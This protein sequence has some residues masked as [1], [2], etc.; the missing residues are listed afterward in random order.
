M[1]RHIARRVFLPRVG[2]RRTSQWVAHGHDIQGSDL[3]LHLQYLSH[4]F[5]IEGANLHRSQA[6]G[7]SLK[8]NV[9]SDVPRFNANVS[10]T[11]P[12]IPVGGSAVESADN[13]V[14]RGVG[15]ES[16]IE[17]RRGELSP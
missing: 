7:R 11:T 4:L 9:L 12:A 17:S 14:H 5:V 1:P 15:N 6:Q 10:L 3:L 2:I 13:D 16:L 8:V